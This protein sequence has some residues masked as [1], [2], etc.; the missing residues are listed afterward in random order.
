MIRPEAAP[1]SPLFDHVFSPGKSENIYRGNQYRSLRRAREKSRWIGR[2]RGGGRVARK[3]SGRHAHF[4]PICP[5]ICN[6]IKINGVGLRK[7]HRPFPDC[8]PCR[9]ARVSTGKERGAL[10]FVRATYTREQ[11]ERWSPTAPDCKG[12]WWSVCRGKRPPLAGWIE[13]VI[14]PR[15]PTRN[16]LR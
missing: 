11:R 15:E 7:K 10:L 5:T 4:P 3:P 12:A 6:N 9:G 13:R 16:N 2:G 14:V 8:S 1:S